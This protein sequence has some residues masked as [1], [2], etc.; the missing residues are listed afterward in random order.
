[1]LNTASR[2]NNMTVT[3]LLISSETFFALINVN[4]I[5]AKVNS[6]QIR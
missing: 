1:M 6:N 4:E 2:T 5:N 3:E